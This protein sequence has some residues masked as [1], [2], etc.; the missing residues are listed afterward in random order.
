MSDNDLHDEIDEL[1]VEIRNK[2]AETNQVLN[3]YEDEF[4]KKYRQMEEADLTSM[5]SF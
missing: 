2:I 3:S 1:A 4:D 5:E